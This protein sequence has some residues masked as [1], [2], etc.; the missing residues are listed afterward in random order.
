MK[1]VSARYFYYWAVPLIWDNFPIYRT[2]CAIMCNTRAYMLRG[3]SRINAGKERRNSQNHS[4]VLTRLC[5][6]S[7]MLLAHSSIR[8]C[9][10]ECDLSIFV[11]SCSSLS[12]VFNLSYRFKSLT[13]LCSAASFTMKSSTSLHTL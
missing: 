1:T 4:Y 10:L 3:F 12:E 5:Q 2:N 8:S 7:L 9:L 13:A 6:K 11:V